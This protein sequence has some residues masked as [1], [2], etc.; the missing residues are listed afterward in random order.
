MNQRLQTG[1]SEQEALQIF[2]DTCEAVARLHQFKTPIIH[3]DLKVPLF[4]ALL[5]FPQEKVFQF[6]P[7]ITRVMVNRCLWLTV[8]LVKLLDSEH[9]I[10]RS[11][12]W[13][14]FSK[15][16]FIGWRRDVVLECNLCM[17]LCRWKTFC[18]MTEDTM[19]CVIL[20]A[21]PWSSRTPRV[22]EWL[23]WRTKLKSNSLQSACFCEIHFV[24]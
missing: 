4:S 22:K 11:T 24:L 2:C 14:F 10:K 23:W 17:T 18:F 1:F 13:G 6:G 12:P 19:F 20:A 21:P 8:T 3:R 9:L 15:H 5:F 7:L 16:Y